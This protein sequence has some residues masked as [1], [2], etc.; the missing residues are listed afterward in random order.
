MAEEAR[1]AAD[2]GLS[3]GEPDIDPEKLFSWKDEVVS[4]LTGGLRTL[5]RGQKSK[6]PAGKGVFYLFQ[7]PFAS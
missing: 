6:L 2:F 3:Y 4:K 7:A 5:V 1:D